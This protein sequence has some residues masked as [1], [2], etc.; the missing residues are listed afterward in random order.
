MPNK[1]RTSTG[2]AVNYSAEHR[3]GYCEVCGA[4]LTQDPK[5]PEEERVLRNHC[6]SCGGYSKGILI[7]RCISIQ[8]P[9]PPRCI[10]FG[11]M[12]EYWKRAVLVLLMGKYHNKRVA[13]AESHRHKTIPQE[14]RTGEHSPETIFKAILANIK[15]TMRR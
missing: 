15:L 6:L 4:R 10:K 13:Y 9:P 8:P 7:S 3:T 12:W 14:Y 5:I 11:C 2:L 1:V